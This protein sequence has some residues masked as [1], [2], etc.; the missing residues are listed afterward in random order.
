MK[1]KR[2]GFL[3]A[4]TVAAAAC[5]RAGSRAM[6]PWNGATPARDVGGNVWERRL[7]LGCHVREPEGLRILIRQS[8]L[9]RPATGRPTEAVKEKK[10]P[11]Y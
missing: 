4:G 3:V 6:C 5:N 2:G 11:A 7:D 8:I 9:Y 10:W 1:T